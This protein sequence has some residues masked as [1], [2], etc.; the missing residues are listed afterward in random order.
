MTST[1]PV[2]ARPDMADDEVTA[3]IGWRAA[4]GRTSP[5][6]FDQ[7]KSLYEDE[8]YA[9]LAALIEADGQALFRR[10]AAGMLPGAQ[11][12]CITTSDE[13][14]TIVSITM[15]H[16]RMLPL[17]EQPVAVRTWRFTG[18]PISGP[19]TPGTNVTLACFAPSQLA[20]LC[21]QLLLGGSASVGLTG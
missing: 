3:L 14:G 13:G 1:T 11:A 2:E 4:H 18:S 9:A 17:I 12:A 10:V 21:T 8:F 15:E 7:H 20:S 16:D 6:E 5:D 19:R